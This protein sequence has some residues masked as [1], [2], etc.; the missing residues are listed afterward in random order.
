MINQ[1]KKLSQT[2]NIP[3]EIIPHT[4]RIVILDQHYLLI[5]NHNGIVY[6]SNCLIKISL[7]NRILHITGRDMDIKQLNCELII[8]EGYIDNINF[9]FL[10]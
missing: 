4:F 6:L 3:L 5:E 8:I 10:E 1:I 2:T 7:N 9:E